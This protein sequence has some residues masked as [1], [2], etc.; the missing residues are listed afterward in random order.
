[1]PAWR[2]RS[3]ARRRVTAVLRVL[4]RRRFV[5][6]LR[7]FLDNRRLKRSGRGPSL[8]FRPASAA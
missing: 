7:V 8:S 5:T 6:L 3:A 1:L 4:A 2:A